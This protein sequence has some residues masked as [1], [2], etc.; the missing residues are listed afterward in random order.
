[1][2]KYQCHKVVE[3]AK[4]ESIRAVGGE[5]TPTGWQIEFVEEGEPNVQVSNAW[6][7]KHQPKCGGYLVVYGDGYLSFSPARAF[8]TGYK[9]V[10][11]EREAAVDFI[12]QM[13]QKGYQKYY[14]VAPSLLTDTAL[15]VELDCAKNWEESGGGCEKAT[16]QEV[17]SFG[18]A[19]AKMKI[20][21]KV[22]RHGWNGNGMFLFIITR[23]AWNFETDIA[24]VDDFEV[25]AFICM[26]SATG[27]LVPWQ[28]SQSDVL[29]LDW[30]LI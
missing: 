24:G 13:E 21:Y 17:M 3:A 5:A 9:P 20:G 30:I 19:V 12:Y 11:L 8:E 23:D 26:K 27:M 28:P 29:A 7:Q 22:A 6:M 4:I 10:T 25:D 15:L 18:D 16:A 1:M 2:K 14:R